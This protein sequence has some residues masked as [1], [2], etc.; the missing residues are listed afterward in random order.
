M[1]FSVP[2]KSMFVKFVFYVFLANDL[3]E[4]VLLRLHIA[5]NNDR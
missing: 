2:Q 1:Q 5:A 4:I 3:T